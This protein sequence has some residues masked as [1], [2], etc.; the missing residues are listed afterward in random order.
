MITTTDTNPC[1]SIDLN[2]I[3]YISR[4]TAEH[5]EYVSI[6]REKLKMAN[7]MFSNSIFR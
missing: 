3:V 2:S 6:K 5:L 1:A 4:F 7:K